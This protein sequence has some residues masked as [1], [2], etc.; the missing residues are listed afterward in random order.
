[1]RRSWGRKLD[2]REALFYILG[3]ALGRGLLPIG[4]ADE[5]RGEAG[6]K[7]DKYWLWAGRYE[8]ELAAQK[9]R[10]GGQK[11]AL[12]NDAKALAA[13]LETAAKERT[14]ILTARVELE[15]PSAQRCAALERHARPKPEPPIRPIEWRDPLLDLKEA[16]EDAEAELHEK[17]VL[18]E[19]A[20]LKAERMAKNLVKLEPCTLEHLEMEFSLRTRLGELGYDEGR[21]KGGKVSERERKRRMADAHRYDEARQKERAAQREE[22]EAELAVVEARC[23]VAC[24]RRALEEK[25]RTRDAHEAVFA[26]SHR[27][28]ALELQLANAI[29]AKAA[30]DSRISELDAALEAAE[31]DESDESEVPQGVPMAASSMNVVQG[32]LV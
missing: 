21:I 14:A 24:A 28:R 5:K 22:A 26:S 29:A 3:W 17:T 18:Q 30:H 11:S 25:Q 13:H 15:L 31:S 32:L 8:S 10:A 16:L 1:M 7:G 23:K 9:K 20:L 19:A 4:P 12:K 6:E 27:V 2:K